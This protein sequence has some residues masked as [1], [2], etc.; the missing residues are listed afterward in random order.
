MAVHLEF[1]R[2]QI[3]RVIL[4]SLKDERQSV[5]QNW[6]EGLINKDWETCDTC[7]IL[8]LHT[9]S[10]DSEHR[11]KLSEWYNTVI[12]TYKEELK[13]LEDMLRVQQNPFQREQLKNKKPELDEWKA[14]QLHDKFYDVFSKESLIKKD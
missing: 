9:L 2:G 12:E 11:L 14:M 5:F 4:T 7:P 10:K 13:L 6:A 1:D 8:L 3:D